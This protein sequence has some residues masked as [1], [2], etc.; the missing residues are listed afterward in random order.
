M[1]TKVLFALFVTLMLAGVITKS[2]ENS[3]N[4][5]ENIS[6]IK[7]E[8]S[9][10]DK[11]YQLKLDWSY[12]FEHWPGGRAPSIVKNLSYT[13]TD[14]QTGEDKKEIFTT[15]FGMGSIAVDNENL[16]FS[17]NSSYPTRIGNRFTNFSAV[18]TDESKLIL[19][20]L[21]INS[22]IERWNCKPMGKIC[23]PEHE[24]E[25]AI[26]IIPEVSSCVKK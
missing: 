10:K 12:E 23:R 6:Q 24:Y 25:E 4:S 21:V 14:L 17:V 16:E 13:L 20:S 7:C 9:V 18:F 2:E 15:R 3:A 5:V 19:Q 22:G 26:E 11:K 8:L 1:K